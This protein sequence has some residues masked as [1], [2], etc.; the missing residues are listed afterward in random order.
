MRVLDEGTAEKREHPLDREY[1]R[2]ECSIQL[3][4]ESD[5]MFQVGVLVQYSGLMIA[6]KMI[7][8]YC[9]PVRRKSVTVITVQ[10]C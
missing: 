1:R 10:Y 6:S 3:M 2:L 7:R 4:A 8:L 9:I 5:P